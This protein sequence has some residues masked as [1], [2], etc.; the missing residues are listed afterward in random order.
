MAEVTSWNVLASILK[1]DPAFA[2]SIGTR[3]L[4][5]S[6]S[7]QP[8]NGSGASSSEEAKPHHSQFPGTH[9]HLQSSPQSTP[10]GYQTCSWKTLKMT[11]AP[12]QQVMASLWFIHAE[13][14]DV[15]V[16]EQT[17]T[18]QSKWCPSDCEDVM[19]TVASSHY[20]LAAVAMGSGDQKRCISNSTSLWD[21]PNPHAHHYIIQQVI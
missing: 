3:M 17:Q 1:G 7:R 8:S 11:S 15:M 19:R 21:A 20:V 16:M 6:L 9:S 4:D 2:L 12:S 5:P 13:A 18:V 14:P 10:A